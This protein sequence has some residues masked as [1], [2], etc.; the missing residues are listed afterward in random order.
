M[1]QNASVDAGRKW[2]S[3]VATASS[4]WPSSISKKSC[5]MRLAS[6]WASTLISAGL[7]RKRALS[8]R[9]LSG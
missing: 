5:S 7:R 6:C 3:S 2:A 8:L 9:M 4:L 1:L